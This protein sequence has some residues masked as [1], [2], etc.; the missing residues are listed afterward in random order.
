MVRFFGIFVVLLLSTVA[1]TSGV[2]AVDNPETTFDEAATTSSLALPSAHRVKLTPPAP[3][4]PVMAEVAPCCPSREVVHGVR[5]AA[6]AWKHRSSPSLQTFL[7][8][9]LI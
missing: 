4:S 1:F 8:T 3:V 2:P 9:F 7:C 6:A 5:G